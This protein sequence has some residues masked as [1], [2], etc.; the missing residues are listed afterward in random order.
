MKVIRLLIFVSF[1]T[2]ALCSCSA[3]GLSPV[4]GSGSASISSAVGVA[5]SSQSTLQGDSSAASS[6]EAV[7]SYDGG[8]WTIDYDA[9]Y[10]TERA[11]GSDSVVFTYTDGDG[12]NEDNMWV[13]VKYNENLTYED[14][15]NR[16]IAAINTTPPGKYT[17]R[18]VT[19][20]GTTGKAFHI[21]WGGGADGADFSGNLTV[22]D[23]YIIQTSSGTYV[24]AASYFSNDES[25]FGVELNRV[26]TSF[27]LK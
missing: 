3:L 23:E 19:I 2:A 22:Y 20:S 21:L 13:A 8:N 18:D 9:D 5:Q 14:T 10:F 16:T 26:A 4:A 17:E 1:M 11:D 24:V 25:T 15:I 7:T 12:N 27:K 6:S